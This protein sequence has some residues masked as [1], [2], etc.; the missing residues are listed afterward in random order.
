M[1]DAERAQRVS[2]AMEAGYRIHTDRAGRFCLVRLGPPRQR[3]SRFYPTRT[4]A[5]TA[6][7]ELS[8]REHLIP[9]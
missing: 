7:V 4:A 2:A 1:T 5:R 3:V 8:L 6:L 9:R